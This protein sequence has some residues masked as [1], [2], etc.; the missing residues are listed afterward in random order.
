MKRSVKLTALP[1]YTA[2]AGILGFLLRLWQKLSGTEASGLLISSHPARLLSIA[3]AVLIPILLVPALWRVKK[4]GSYK[5]RFPRS[6]PAAIGAWIAAAG[7]LLL[8]STTLTNERTLLGILMGILSLPTALCLILTGIF[9][10][11]STRPN[12]LFHG[13]ITVFFMVVALYH[14][15]V[16]SAE[17]QLELFCYEALACVS[18]ML[19][20]YYRTTLDAKQ[21][22]WKQFGYFS[23]AAMFF[24]FL[25]ASGSSGW[26]YLSIDSL[27]LTFPVGGSL[28]VPGS[29]SGLLIVR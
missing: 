21:Q 8:G 9:R 12:P 16:W 27:L 25:A 5:K 6:V 4:T 24:C 10:L 15:P 19:A 13:I 26:F 3:I 29:L 1:L 20:S 2:A 23:L 14:Y 28:L 7:V 17:P 18:L 22:N 11:R